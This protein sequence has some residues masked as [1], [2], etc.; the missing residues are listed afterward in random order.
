MDKIMQFG[1]SGKIIVTS[2]FLA[3]LTFNGSF[4]NI[5]LGKGTS[6]HFLLTCSAHLPFML[7]LCL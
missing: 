4:R 2:Y 6:L 5:K 7:S 1:L 3:F